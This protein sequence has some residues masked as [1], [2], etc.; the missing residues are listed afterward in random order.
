MIG[1]KPEKILKYTCNDYRMEMRLLGMH[2]QLSNV[3]LSDSDREKL[4]NE[5]DLLEEEIGLLLRIDR[6]LEEVG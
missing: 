3:E 1:N 5:I 4:Q 2:Q 6:R